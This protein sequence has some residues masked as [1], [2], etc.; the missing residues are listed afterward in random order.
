MSDFGGLPQL[1]Q[2][3]LDNLGGPSSVSENGGD[4]SPSDPPSNPTEISLRNVFGQSFG[5]EDARPSFPFSPIESNSDQLSNLLDFGHFLNNAP[6]DLGIA[7]L[8]NSSKTLKCPKCNWHY[9]YQETL[10][11]HMKEKHSETEIRCAYCVENRPHPKLS[12]G[13]TYSCGY[14]PYRCELCKYSTTT[15]GNLSIHMQSDKHLHAVQELPNSLVNASITVPSG[16][17]NSSQQ[18]QIAQ[19]EKRFV[20]GVCGNFTTDSLKE[21]LEHAERDRSRASL[22]D[23]SAVNGVFICHL[24]PYKTN[25]K[26]NFQLHTR[27]DKH[28]QRVQMVNHVREGAGSQNANL[29]R[30][31]AMKGPF[32]VLCRPCQEIFPSSLILREHCEAVPHK[33]LVRLPIFQ[34]TCNICAFITPHKHEAISECFL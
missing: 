12:R 32:Q 7:A 31:A 5:L 2:Y 3:G 30:L 25:L 13:E 9:K 27:T 34:M 8:R 11:I 26:A 21:M 29:S 22:S 15:K 14:K 10:E 4:N 28:L 18:L 6:L 17:S 24:C 1:A 16:S 33:S 20:C 23:V 19:L